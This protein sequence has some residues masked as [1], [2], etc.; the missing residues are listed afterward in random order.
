V[1]S[2]GEGG[3]REQRLE[4][5]IV[6]GLVDFDDVSYD[7]QADL[8]YDLA[9]QV[10]RHLRSY[11]SEEETGRVL[12]FHQRALCALIHAQMHEPGHY[13]EKAE[14]GYE[15]KVYQGFTP[16]IRRGVFTASGPVSDYRTEPADKTK[17][18]QMLF[19]GFTK[20]LYRVQKFQSDTERRFAVILERDAVRW[21]KPASGQFQITY[22]R[23]PDRPM[24]VPD[25]VAETDTELLMIETKARNEMTTTEVAAKRQAAE[26]WCVNASTHAATYGGKPWRYALV[27][28]DVIAE[29]MGL[30]A[31]VA[32]S[33]GG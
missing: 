22:R 23:G 16:I 4:N 10:V 3:I 18:G 31:L 30:T 12:Q 14:G 25:F 9:G 7:E 1:L 2:T 29:N 15:A 33:V 20:C 21:F 8:L 26:E 5:Y 6:R 17:I 11:L 13:W 28:H 32:T 19:G 27:P 24:Y